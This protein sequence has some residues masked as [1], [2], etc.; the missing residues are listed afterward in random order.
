MVVGVIAWELHIDGCSSLKQKRAIV[1]SLKDRLRSRHN[2]SVAETDHQDAW[3][4][5][6]ICAVLV[7]SDRR[8]AQS[9][10]SRLDALVA[11]DGRVRVMDTVTYYY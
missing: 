2:V 10:I 6:E 9:I 8:R 5:A 11:G 4:H 1:R 7:S 3:Q